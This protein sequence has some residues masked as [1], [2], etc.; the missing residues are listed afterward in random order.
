[1]LKAELALMKGGEDKE[2]LD[3]YDIE[4]CHKLVED[5]VKD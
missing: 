2:E 3:K 4:D 5:Y 1:M